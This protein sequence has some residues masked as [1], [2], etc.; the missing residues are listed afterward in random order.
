[1]LHKVKKKKRDYW[2]ESIRLLFIES[3][4]HLIVKNK[5]GEI[6]LIDG[7]QLVHSWIIWEDAVGVYNM[8]HTTK[9][10]LEHHFLAQG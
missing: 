9:D 8:K 5:K 6:Y 1:M 4:I 10:L 3:Y 7:S 2:S